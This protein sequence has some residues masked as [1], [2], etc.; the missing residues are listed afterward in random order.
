MSM[1]VTLFRLDTGERVT[2]VFSVIDDET[3]DDVIAAPEQSEAVDVIAETNRPG[4]ETGGEIQGSG[5]IAEDAN[6]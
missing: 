6:D 2:S 1:G 5:D 3:A 4:D